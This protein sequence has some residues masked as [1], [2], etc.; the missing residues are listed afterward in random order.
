MK[1]EFT[2]AKLSPKT[3]NHRDYIRA[4]VES[5]VT[6]CTGPAGT[7]KTSLATGL[8]CEWLRDGK[9]SR[10]LITRPIVECG[11]SELG[12]LPGDLVE[13]IHPYLRPVLDEIELYI[14]HLQ[15]IQFIKNRTIDIVPLNVMRGINCH[16][17]FMILDEASNAT[18]EQIKMFLTRIGKNSKCVINGDLKQY[19]LKTRQ[20]GGLSSIIEKLQNI[21]GISTIQLTIADI[22]RS[23][24]VGRILRALNV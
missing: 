4:M 3:Q 21:Q 20:A 9:I 6:I 22:V 24:V 16:N 11:D 14:E 17:C 13:K 12:I 2:P 1:K 15:I 8:A 19:D 7:L 10:I 5:D 18:F 23:D